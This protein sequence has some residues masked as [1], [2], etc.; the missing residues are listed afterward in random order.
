MNIP[1]LLREAMGLKAQVCQT[2]GTK[3]RNQIPPNKNVSFLSAGALINVKREANEGKQCFNFDVPNCR[4]KTSWKGTF[5]LKPGGKA[6][7][8]LQTFFFFFF[9]KSPENMDT[10][11]T[12]TFDKVRN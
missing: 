5:G 4:N 8:W 10:L 6:I 7:L 9:F 11:F 3:Y 1:W 2:E 12:V